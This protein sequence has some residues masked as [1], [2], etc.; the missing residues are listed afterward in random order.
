MFFVCCV[1]GVFVCMVGFS[2]GYFEFELCSM[3]GLG[4]IGC[5]IVRL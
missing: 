3:L 5:P 2:V 4:V 1:V